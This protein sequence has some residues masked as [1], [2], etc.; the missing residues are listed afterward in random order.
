MFRVV[1]EQRKLVFRK[2]LL[3]NDGARRNEREVGDRFGFRFRCRGRR[4]LLSHSGLG[5]SLGLGDV[6]RRYLDRGEEPVVILW[7]VKDG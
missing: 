5:F 6:R 7:L 4:V 3:G 1:R 2:W